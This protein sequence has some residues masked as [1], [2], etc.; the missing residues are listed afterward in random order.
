MDILLLKNHKPQIPSCASEGR[1]HVCPAGIR[2]F[3]LPKGNRDA[4]ERR[5]VDFN[6]IFAVKTF[7]FDGSDAL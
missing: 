3:P 2:G 7:V 1:R 5:F 6:L 4:D